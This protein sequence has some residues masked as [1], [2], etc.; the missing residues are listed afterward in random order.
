MR[1][2]AYATCMLAPRCAAP[3][4][5][6]L[7]AA[8]LAGCASSIDPPVTPEEREYAAQ[9]AQEQLLKDSGDDGRPPRCAGSTSATRLEGRRSRYES[10]EG[11]A[12]RNCPP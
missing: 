7:L 6:L 10:V 11:S 2:R 8:G 5:L 9:K 12:A 1:G 3:A 4:I